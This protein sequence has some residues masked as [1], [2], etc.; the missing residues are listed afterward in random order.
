MSSVWNLHTGEIEESDV[1]VAPK[2][3]NRQCIHQ[4]THYIYFHGGCRRVGLPVALKAEDSEGY[5]PRRL[6]WSI[7]SCGPSDRAHHWE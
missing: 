3:E 2:V 6:T 7:H 5:I 4:L 1:Y